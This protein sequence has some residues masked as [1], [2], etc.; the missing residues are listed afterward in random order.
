MWLPRQGVR[1]GRAWFTGLTD[2]EPILVEVGPAPAGRV[3]I[4]L[5]LRVEAA[6]L[7]LVLA[8]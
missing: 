7:P 3:A 6:G 5:R 2:V 4:W 1:S 8:G